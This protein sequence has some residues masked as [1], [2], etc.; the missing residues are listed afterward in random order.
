MNDLENQEEKKSSTGKFNIMIKEDD[1]GPL[2]EIQLVWNMPAKDIA[3]TQ[4]QDGFCLKIIEEV[5]KK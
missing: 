2:P 3:K 4:R 5:Q 1:K